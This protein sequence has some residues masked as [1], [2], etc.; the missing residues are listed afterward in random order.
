MQIAEKI[1]RLVESE[2]FVFEQERIVVTIILGVATVNE[3]VP[4]LQFIR[5]ADDCLYRAKRNGRNQVV[6]D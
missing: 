2:P 4:V 1:R 5:L 6:S 3:E